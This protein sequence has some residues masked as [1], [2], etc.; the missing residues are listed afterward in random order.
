AAVCCGRTDDVAWLN[1]AACEESRVDSIVIPTLLACNI[2]DG[3]AKLALRNDQCFIEFRSTV[4]TGH[5][6]QVGDEVSK[7]S[8]ELRG[9]SID[10]RTELVNI[11]VIIPTA[12]SDHDVARAQVRSHQIARHDA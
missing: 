12:K 3:A 7:S 9:R 4:R 1:T 6:G 8:V 2:S 5:Y 11:R 10:P